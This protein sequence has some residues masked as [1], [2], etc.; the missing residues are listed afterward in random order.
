MHI[1][2]LSAN[3]NIPINIT[4][5]VFEKSIDKFLLCC[6]VL[7]SCLST[8]RMPFIRTSQHR[9]S[10]SG[11]LSKTIS[12]ML[13]G[14]W[15]LAERDSIVK[16]TIIGSYN[17]L[18]PGRPY[19]IN[20][21]ILLIWHLRIPLSEIWVEFHSFSLKEMHLKMSSAKLAAIYFGVNGL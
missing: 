4:K 9:R 17:G 16:A 10:L 18:S 13:M 21:C 12:V 1:L 8:I 7:V 20:T 3:F 11:L 14:I 5:S 15:K 2:S 6:E 19:W